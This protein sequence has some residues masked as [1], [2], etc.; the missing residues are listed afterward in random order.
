MLLGN[1]SELRCRR[2]SFLCRRTRRQEPVALP[3]LRPE[4]SANSRTASGSRDIPT[5]ESTAQV[6]RPLFDH[7][8]SP[9]RDLSDLCVWA[10]AAGVDSPPI[11]AGTVSDSFVRMRKR[12]AVSVPLGPLRACQLTAFRPPTTGA[13]LNFSEGKPLRT[14]PFA[15]LR[16]QLEPSR[17]RL[18]A[19]RMPKSSSYYPVTMAQ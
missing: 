2:S 14:T 12:A 15:P 7:G 19:G 11:R 10:E 13:E 5:K 1:P 16:L 3:A 18:P 6:S 17:F 8:Q 9:L 4:A